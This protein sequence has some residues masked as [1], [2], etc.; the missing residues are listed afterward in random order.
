MIKKSLFYKDYRISDARPLEIARHYVRVS[1][2]CETVSSFLDCEF[3]GLFKLSYEPVWDRALSVRICEDQL[4]YFFKTLLEIVYGRKTL[5]VDMRIDDGR[6]CI[7]LSTNDHLPITPEEMTRLAAIARRVG[8]AHST[9]NDALILSCA[10]FRTAY[11]S[12]RSISSNRLRE[13]LVEIFFTGGPPV[14]YEE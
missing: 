13:K 1:T 5:S 12:L 11:A 4:A 8:M 7:T 9:S 10:L 14:I 6:F 2:V 3:T